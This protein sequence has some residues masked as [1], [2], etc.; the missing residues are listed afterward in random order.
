MIAILATGDE[1]IYGDTLNTNGYAIANAL[2][3]E[4]LSIG[5]HLSCG[6]NE[7]ELLACLEF[8]CKK[9]DIIILTGGL[10]PTSDDLT[11]F[12][13]ARFLKTTLIEFPDALTHIQAR[14]A[15]ANLKL[16]SGNRQQALFP[17]DATILPNPHGTAMGC[18]CRAHDKLFILLPGPPRECL[19]MFNEHVLPVLQ[20]TQHT[21]KCLLKWRLF[22]VAEG[23]I[24]EILGN[25][26]SGVN[27]EIGYRLET[28][29]VEF[30][31]RCSAE[32]VETIKSIIEPLIRP[33]I[34]ASPEQKAS[35]RLR[36][37][38]EKMRVPITII[39]DATG[40]VMQ[41]LLQRPSTHQWLTFHG[42]ESDENKLYFHLSGLDEYWSQQLGSTTEVTITYRHEKKHGSEKHKIPYRSPLVV[43]YAAEWLS[44]RVLHLIN[45]LHQGVT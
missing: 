40:G 3:S 7:Q 37:T 29:Y 23:E 44:F 20:K 32:Q 13:L 38:I 11:R 2:T 5:F 26:L 15:R 28:P 22:G 16:N 1:I 42:T 41:T 8:L 34:I 30:K 17:P 27:C 14:L 24:A 6:D 4:G 45:Q 31:V 25:A 9:H 10:G 36:Q 21:D 12:A 19:P 33:H 43:D 18:Y 39:D 35:E